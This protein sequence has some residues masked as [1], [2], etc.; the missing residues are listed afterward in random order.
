MALIEI[1]GWPFLKMV[2]FPW[3][4]EITRWYKGYCVKTNQDPEDFFL[5]HLW[6]SRH[7]TPRSSK[8]PMFISLRPRRKWWR[9]FP[10][11][12][13]KAWPNPQDGTGRGPSTG[14]WIRNHP[15]DDSSSRPGKRLHSYWSH[16]SVEIVDLPSYIAWWCSIV[17]L[18][19][20]QKV[21]VNKMWSRQG[22]RKS[23][24]WWKHVEIVEEM[25]SCGNCVLL[26]NLW[27]W[28]FSWT[29]GW[30]EVMPEN[31]RKPRSVAI[32]N[33]DFHWFSILVPVFECQKHPKN[34][35]HLAHS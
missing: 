23:E 17:F 15:Q 26:R 29:I 22:H 18:Y 4:C 1:D 16:G 11:K 2:F 32:A 9:V 35:S 19:V 25:S 8:L 5:I 24:S 12:R 34:P 28:E 6:L 7:C 33:Y 10:L 13:F 31:T 14:F 3:L 20:Y 21:A 27:V 30:C